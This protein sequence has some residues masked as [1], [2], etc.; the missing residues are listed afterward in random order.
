MASYSIE[1]IKK[2]HK[3]K[4]LKLINLGKHYI[5]K[6]E[7]TKKLFKDYDVDIDY[8]D[9]IPTAFAEIDTSAKTVKGNVY[10]SYKLLCD[11]SFFKDLGYLVHEYNHVL[12]QVTAEEPIEGVKGTS[13][14]DYL[15][16]KEEVEAFK[17][18]INYLAD[19]FSVEEAEKYID[20]LLDH[21][22]IHGDFREEKEEELSAQ[23]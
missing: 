22:K 17:N 10:L 12:Q 18:Q 15:N 21:H 11:G 1:Q 2:I 8:I 19:E 5:K 6:N 16:N 4:L 7:V 23:I 9:L 13:G 3:A 14:K 20:K